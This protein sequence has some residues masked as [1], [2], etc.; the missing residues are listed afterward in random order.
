[1]GIKREGEYPAL[2][3]VGKKVLGVEIQVEGAQGGHDPVSQKRV[4]NELLLMTCGGRADSYLV[5]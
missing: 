2:K 4:L 5:I 1:M 3:A